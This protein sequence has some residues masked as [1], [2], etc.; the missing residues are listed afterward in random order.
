MFRIETAGDFAE[1]REIFGE[2][3]EWIGVS[4]DFQNFETE[5]A[6][7]PGDYAAPRGLLLIARAEDGRV[8]ACGALRSLDDHLCEMKRLY[9]RREYRG[10]ALGRR[11]AAK[12]IEHAR[13]LGYRAMRLDTLPKMQDAMRLYESLGF[14]DIE[15]YRYNPIEGSRFME[16]GL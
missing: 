10:H 12:L 16:L 1:V 11:I 15:P 9:V 3:A 4:L 13:L 2:Y 5:L 8:A 7:L 14:I 6:T